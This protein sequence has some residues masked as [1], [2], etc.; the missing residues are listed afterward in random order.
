MSV[1][2]ID[3]E[4]HF[5]KLDS[6]AEGSSFTWIGQHLAGSYFSLETLEDGNI[7]NKWWS[8]LSAAYIQNP[9]KQL[10]C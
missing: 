2:N 7:K 5:F 6:M 1:M 3:L 4:N 9:Y 8:R 10:S